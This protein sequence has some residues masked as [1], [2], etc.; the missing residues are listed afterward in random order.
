MTRAN[1]TVALDLTNPGQF[2]ACCGLL[3]VADRCWPG[4]E[5]WFDGDL[6]KL[7][8]TAASLSEI[9]SPLGRCRIANTMTASQLMRLERL[10]GLSRKERSA[11][12]SFDEEKKSLEALRRESPILLTGDISLRIDW[13]ADDVAGGSRFKTW[14][15]QQSVLDIATAMHQGLRQG[16]S[17]GLWTSVR[18]AGLPFNFDSDL[19]SQGSPLDIGFSFNPL[20]ASEATRIR[21]TCKP[22]LE[23]L[24]FVGLQRFRPSNRVSRESRFVYS[25]WKT[26]L[27]PTVASA[28]VCGALRVGNEAV[29]EF[30][31]LYR[32]D[33]LKSFLPAVGFQGERDE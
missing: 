13:F 7:R 2:F 30:S 29:F 32:S 3:E 19:G 5:G 15:G 21:E 9:I 33:Y 20:R 23:F 24:C 26:P 4:S 28:V 11:A 31:M 18:G 12:P 27:L 10:S 22:A 16:A 25:A 17:E 1:I 14:A 6:F 8:T